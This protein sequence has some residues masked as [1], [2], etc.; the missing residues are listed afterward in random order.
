[1]NTSVLSFVQTP[2]LLCADNVSLIIPSYQRPYVWQSEDVTG[3]LDQII[4][5]YEVGAPHYYIGTILTSVVTTSSTDSTTYEV[6]DGQ[7]RMTTLMLLALALNAVVPNNSLGRFVVVAAQPRLVFAI[8]E[9]VQ[10]LLGHWAGLQA[11]VESRVSTEVEGTYLKHLTAARKALSD[12]LSALLSERDEAFMSDVADYI[13]TQVKW[14]NN[15][16][17]KGMDLNR[18]FS[19]MNNSGVQLEQSDILKSRLLGKIEK[20]KS[21]YDAIWQ[22]CENM[23]DYFER[24][25]RWV[26]PSADWKNLNSEDLAEHCAKTFPLDCATTQAETGMSIAQLARWAPQKSN[27]DEE[28]TSERFRNCRSIISFSL[29]LMHTYRIYL[30]QWEED[31][32]EIG[33]HDS[34]LNEY[35]EDFVA[36]LDGQRAQNFIECLWQVRFQFDRWVVK[37]RPEDGSTLW[38]LRLTNVHLGK[39]VDGYR[40]N[41]TSLES[42]D[43]SQLQSVRNFTGER[44][45]QYWLTPFLGA[46]IAGEAN[47]TA[48]VQAL[49]ERIDNQLSLADVSQ[50]AA[51]F[52]LLSGTRPAMR[53]IADVVAHLKVP[54]GTRFEHYWFQKL[55]YILWR[56]RGSFNFYDPKK[57]ATYRVTSKNSIEHVHPQKEEFGRLMDSQHLDSFGNLVLLSPSE[58]SSYSNQ[59]VGKKRE[60]FRDKDRYDSLK[61]AHMFNTKADGDWDGV[62]I[63]QH[64][65]QM[66]GLIA[67]HYGE[68]ND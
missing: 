45:A 26:F 14:V 58:N 65:E 37:W 40:L 17:P 60:D 59:S 12:H 11:D 38:H 33:L 15:I 36:H 3:L 2:S 64:Q 28:E 27:D 57:L 49:L 44:S 13:F 53:D 46:L 5:A 10:R 62:A 35:F 42:S 63:K 20:N 9:E 22:A 61:L 6:I 19:T 48:Q 51:S 8:R 32:V 21:R 4:A 1:M 55:E 54:Q 47:S 23:H 34:R 24:N 29:L 68:A 41:R 7:Q 25:L 39:T 66:L 43:L 30:H 18:L 50:K 31:D 56:E 16:M 52:D 67:R